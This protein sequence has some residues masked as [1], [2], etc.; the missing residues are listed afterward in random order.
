[1]MKNFRTVLAAV[2]LSSTMFLSTASAQ[3]AQRASPD[4]P[5]HSPSIRPDTPSRK[6]YSANPTVSTLTNDLGALHDDATYATLL[7]DSQT[8]AAKVATGAWS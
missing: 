7:A 4:S 8:M 3:D 1:M 5:R 2:V 6:R